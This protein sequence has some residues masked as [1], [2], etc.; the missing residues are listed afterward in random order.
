VRVPLRLVIVPGIVL[1]LLAGNACRGRSGDAGPI[2]DSDSPDAGPIIDSDSPEAGPIVDSDS[3]DAGPII[4]FDIPLGVEAIRRWDAW[5]RLRPGVRT[6]MRSTHDPLGGNASADASHFIRRDAAGLSVPLDLH[7][8]GVLTFVRHNR[9]HGSPWH[10]QVDGHETVVQ[11]TSSATPDTPIS[12]S[13]WEPA[14]AFPFPLARTWSETLGADLSWVPV[15]FSTSLTLGY[16]RTHYGTGY[17][18][19]QLVH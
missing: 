14:D 10:Y 9:W 6:V 11:E 19:A 8:P 5:P 7:G 3:P 16:E 13:V 1:P 12:G 15:P 18:I 2:V 4:D 17:F